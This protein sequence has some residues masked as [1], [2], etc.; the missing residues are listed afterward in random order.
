M[1]RY[2]SAMR[3]CDV[4]DEPM[5]AAPDAADPATTVHGGDRILA[6]V[7]TRCLDAWIDAQHRPGGMFPPT[8]KTL[9]A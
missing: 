1:P 8:D 7:H 4:C 9:E 3:C 2:L 6:V 5:S